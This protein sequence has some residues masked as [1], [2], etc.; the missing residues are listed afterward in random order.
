MAEAA[1]ATVKRT[2]RRYCPF[3]TGPR[4]QIAGSEANEETHELQEL[5]QPF[6][7]L[8]AVIGPDSHRR[9]PFPQFALDIVPASARDRDPRRGEAG[10][11]H[12]ICPSSSRS[13]R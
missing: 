1:E 12:P 11:Q 10:P 5:A 7:G 3:R 9:A 2:A 6:A 8:E 4:S 13:E